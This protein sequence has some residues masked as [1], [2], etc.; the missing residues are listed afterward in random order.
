M[1]SSMTT[2]RTAAAGA[3]ALASC[4]GVAHTYGAG[5]AAVVAVHD[6][7]CDLFAHSRIA[8]TGPSGSGKSTLL[9][10]IAGLENVT[11]GTLNWP[12]LGADPL[13]HPGRIGVV[14]QG[15]SL[16]P[17]LT[18]L[19]NV[20]FP[21]LIAGSTDDE[22]AELGRLALMRL[23]IGDLADALPQELSG[24]QS[25]RVAV[26]RVL[27]SRPRLILADEPTGQLDR[28]AADQVLDVLLRSADDLGAALVVA[29][30]DPLV[31]DRLPTRWKMRDGR[32]LRRSRAPDLPARSS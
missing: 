11:A 8:I 23:G 27:A 32:L 19:E 16:L 29:T 28:R 31:A 12:D 25:Q 18:A 9:H 13:T 14:F 5:L 26:A 4:R 24:G 15:P 10:L 22:A 21:L 7:T 3:V 20:S 30:H 2:D 17:A 1:T 6:V